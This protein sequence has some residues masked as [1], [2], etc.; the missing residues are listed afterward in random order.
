MVVA[1]N[2]RSKTTPRVLRRQKQCVSLSS[3][4]SSR[5]CKVV[6]AR[7]TRNYHSPAEEVLR[8]LAPEHG[9]SHF[10]TP[11][12]HSG[13]H[14]TTPVDVEQCNILFPSPTC[15]RSPTRSVSI[16]NDSPILSGSD[17]I[18]VLNP[19]GDD[20]PTVTTVKELPGG[21]VSADG[22]VLTAGEERPTDTSGELIPQNEDKGGLTFRDYPPQPP[23][24]SLIFSESSFNVPLPFGEN[25]PPLTISLINRVDYRLSHLSS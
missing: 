18:V 22:D 17:A 11:M 2:T 13:G 14:W 1:N 24:D 9:T 6:S 20:P 8:A 15:Q 21:S 5:R 16:K 23:D 25:N 7:G 3:K 12:H 4:G 19:D 10:I